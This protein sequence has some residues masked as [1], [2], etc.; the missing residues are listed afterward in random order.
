MPEPTPDALWSDDPTF[1]LFRRAKAGDSGA[2]EALIQRC[3]PNLTRWAR[4]RLPP[5]ARGHL[6]T[7]DLVQDAIL[8]MVARIDRFE[9]RHAGAMQAYLRQSVLNR[10]RDEVRRIDRRGISVEL[11][12]EIRGHEPSPLERAIQAQRYEHYRDALLRLSGK[13]RRLVI[14]RFEAEWALPT[15][16]TH[17]GFNSSDAARMAVTRALQRLLGRLGTPD[18]VTK[19][20]KRRARGPAS[21]GRPDRPTPAYAAGPA[22]DTG[23]RPSPPTPTRARQ[24]R[25]SPRPEVSSS[26]G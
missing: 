5:R 6:D 18:R 24:R 1:E 11:P 14:A 19:G 20:R 13:D 15:I 17:F 26:I 7:C 12:D 9:P 22:P 16:V 25:R 10:I 2:V 3:L 4:G 8:S 23:G 21:A